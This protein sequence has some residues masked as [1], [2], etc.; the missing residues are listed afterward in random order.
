MFQKDPR[1]ITVDTL[2]AVGKL[3]KINKFSIPK[4]TVVQDEKKESSTKEIKETKKEV[5]PKSKKEIKKN[6]LPNKYYEFNA[7]G[8]DILW[9]GDH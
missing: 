8:K 4:T 1:I 9:V 6:T 2:V 3:D 7:K 5:Q